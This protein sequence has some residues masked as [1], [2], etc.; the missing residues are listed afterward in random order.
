MVLHESIF[1]LK[2]LLIEYMTSYCN[3][4]VCKFASLEKDESKPS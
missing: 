2:T 4:N 3:I 1:H